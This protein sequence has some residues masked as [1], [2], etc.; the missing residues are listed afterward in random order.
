[1]N[2]PGAA[3]V[4]EEI[5]GPRATLELVEAAR[6]RISIRLEEHE[7]HWNSRYLGATISIVIAGMAAGQPWVDDL[8]DLL[9]K[10]SR[11]ALKGVGGVCVVVDVDAQRDGPAKQQVQT[12]VE[13]QLR[14]AGVPILTKSA[15]WDTKGVPVLGVRVRFKQCGADI[16]LY[17]V[18]MT[19]DLMEVVRLDRKPEAKCFART[20]S[21]EL[22]GT[23]G[24]ANLSEIRASVR[25]LVDEFANAFLAEN[26]SAAATRPA[27]P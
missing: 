15:V 4:Q 2:R 7:M 6:S 16:P 8:D 24:A 5:A 10:V 14:K 22:H 20:W 17:A 9:D 13:L 11:S 21:R 1:M 18:W 19:A 26:P 12:D 25:D 27:Q 23:I 3:A